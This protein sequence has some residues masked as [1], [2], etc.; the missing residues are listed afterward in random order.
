MFWQAI[1]NFLCSCMG[2]AAEYAIHRVPTDIVD[3]CES[4]DVGS[5]DEMRE[6]L[7]ELL[8]CLAI[9]CEGGDLEGGVKGEEANDFF[10]CVSRSSEYGDSSWCLVVG[11]LNGKAG[12]D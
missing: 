10:S 1:K 11:R 6:D 12:G 7:G 3:L 2:K 5:S 8:A 9:S 4:W